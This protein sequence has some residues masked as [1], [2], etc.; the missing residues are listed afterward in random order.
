MVVNSIKIY[1]LTEYNFIENQNGKYESTNNG[2]NSTV[3]NSYIPLD[4][5]NYS[6]KYNITVNA[7]ISTQS[8]DYGY[9]TINKDQTAPSYNTQDGRFVY[10]T[11][12]QSAKDYTYEIDGGYQYYLHLGYYKN[13]TT[14]TSGNDV[15]RVSSVNVS[16]S[17]SQLY[18]TSATTNSE[19]QAITQIPFGK[20]S[21]TE[22]NTPEG[23]KPLERPV[24][25]EFRGTDDAQHEF[26]IEN[27]KLAKVIVHHYIKGTST[28]LAE[29]EEYYGNVDESYTTSPRLDI[30]KY[31][32]EKDDNDEYILP[33]NATGQYR[34]R[35]I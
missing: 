28:K 2:K 27:E 16:L 26:T 13:G 32:L 8:G 31:S 6:G 5:T 18:H 4:L 23:Y 24:E 25:I 11:G 10:I 15:F 7:E 20:Y 17:G 29:D 19:G 14:N 30:P 3:C 33:T 1:G 12:E 22:V 9:V 35:T 21:V 34:N